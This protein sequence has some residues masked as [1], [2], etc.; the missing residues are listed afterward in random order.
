MF[1]TSYIQLGS[2]IMLHSIYMLLKC[3]N[4][5]KFNHE[6]EEMREMFSPSPI[7]LLLL[8]LLPHIY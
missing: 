2:C 1:Q 5:E 6:D 8:L 4:N 7:L 3:Q